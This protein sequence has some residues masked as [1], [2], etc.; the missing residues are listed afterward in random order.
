MGGSI[1]AESLSSRR[2]GKATFLNDI[3]SGKKKRLYG[4]WGFFLQ[5]EF[6][7]GYERR[8]VFFPSVF[9]LLTG[10]GQSR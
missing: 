4:F 3:R 5:D 9:F 10:V 7:V 1:D 2:G 6:G 8:G